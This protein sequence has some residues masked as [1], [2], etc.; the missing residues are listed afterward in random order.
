MAWSPSRVRGK[1]GQD[2]NPCRTPNTPH[3]SQYQARGVHP[4]CVPFTAVTPSLS[5][6]RACPCQASQLILPIILCGAPGTD[7]LSDQPRLTQL[8]NAGIPRATDLVSSPRTCASA[9]YTTGCPL[10]FPS[11]TLPDA[12]LKNS[13]FSLHPLLL[14]VSLCFF[15]VEHLY[16]AG[17]L[18]S[19][20]RKSKG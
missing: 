20:H 17:C 14:F 5:Q 13:H 7:R 16:Y 15:S 11:P 4:A 10:P 12:I 18:H 6:V 3:R 9:P 2:S 8:S 19:L 1:K